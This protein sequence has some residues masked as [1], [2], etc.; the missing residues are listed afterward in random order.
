MSK[1]ANPQKERESESGSQIENPGKDGVGVCTTPH[2]PTRASHTHPRPPPAHTHA[3][4]PARPASHTQTQPTPS[5]G[6]A[7]AAAAAGP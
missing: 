6:T 7:A 2:L 5:P 1:L 3:P 4:A